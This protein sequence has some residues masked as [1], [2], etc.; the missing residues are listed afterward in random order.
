MIASFDAAHA[1]CAVT[2]QMAYSM[3]SVH[4]SYF[5]VVIS[6]KESVGYAIKIKARVVSTQSIDGRYEIRLKN[7]F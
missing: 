7:Y 6:K 5:I 4:T 1:V 2:E 3:Q